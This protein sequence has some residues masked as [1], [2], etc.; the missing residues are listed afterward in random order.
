MDNRTYRIGFANVSDVHPFGA[1]VRQGLE[2]TAAKHPNISLMLRDN[3]LDSEKALAHTREFA[4]APVDLAIIFHI[5]ERIGPDIAH[6]LIDKGI[7]VIAVDIPILRSTFFGANNKR[8]GTLAGE[9]LG[10]WIKSHWEGQVDKV[11]VATDQRVLEVV[12][13]RIDFALKGLASIVEYKSSNVLYFDG[14]NDRALCKERSLPVLERWADFHRIAV[15]G[16]ADN[17]VLGV[18][19]AARELGRE[20]DIVA[21]GHGAEMG[22]DELRNP[23][24]RFIASTA[25]FPEKYGERLIELALKILN[26]ERVPRENY[27]DHVA[28]TTENVNQLD[29][30]PSGA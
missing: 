6:M 7:P 28:V 25:F 2:T 15:C 13:Q 22:I 17:S 24:S 5:D 9:A 29:Q 20:A 18:V 3:D 1:I 30:S 10:N 14:G 19:D 21:V 26:G 8:A 11:L 12:R 27:I 16:L 4:E 23:D